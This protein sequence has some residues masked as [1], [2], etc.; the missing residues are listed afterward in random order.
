[1]S[2]MYGKV[3]LPFA[4]QI[5]CAMAF[6]SGRGAAIVEANA[7]ESMFDMYDK[8]IILAIGFQRIW[9]RSA[10]SARVAALADT[11]A[12]ECLMCMTK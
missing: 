8:M 9:A 2:D 7:A 10:Q 6:K 11:H 5:T 3:I 4:F 1:M 12:A